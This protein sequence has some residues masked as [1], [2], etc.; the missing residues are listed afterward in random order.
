MA[1]VTTASVEWKERNKH[2]VAT[3]ELLEADGFARIEYVDVEH[4]EPR[5]L[6]DFD[7]VFIN[8]GNPFYLLH[9]LTRSGADRV[10]S[11]L[12]KQG[13][14][15]VGSSAGAMVLGPD[16]SLVAWFTPQM[17]T[18]GMTDL[19][20]LS[21]VPL[22]VYP[23][24]GRREEDEAEIRAYETSSG[25]RVT[26]LRD[27]EAILWNEAAPMLLAPDGRTP[28]TVRVEIGDP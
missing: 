22:T 23:H 7:A 3:K 15:M 5:R 24:Y 17:N 10:L 8:G 2:A 11:D 20:A 26:R 19:R 16:L 21:L 13:A 28:L 18:M 14:P 12:V 27:T 4:D 6:R 1:I 25:R 9:H